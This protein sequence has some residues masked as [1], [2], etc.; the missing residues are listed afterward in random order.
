[1]VPAVPAVVSVSVGNRETGEYQSLVALLTPLTAGGSTGRGDMVLGDEATPLTRL[2]LGAMLVFGGLLAAPVLVVRR[3]WRGEND[4]RIASLL[5][6][7]GDTALCTTFLN[8]SC[9]FKISV[10]LY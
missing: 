1:V 5:G 4:N 2:W 8:T 9:F 3:G 7:W 6:E 10:V